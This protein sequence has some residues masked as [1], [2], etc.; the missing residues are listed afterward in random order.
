MFLQ[1][2]DNNMWPI[3]ENGNY[4]PYDKDLTV[5]KNFKKGNLVKR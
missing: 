2:Q 5:K 1:S 4:V 3:V